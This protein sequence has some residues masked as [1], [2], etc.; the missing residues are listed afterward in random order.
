MGVALKNTDLRQE[1]AEYRQR[2][3][4][5]RELRYRAKPIKAHGIEDQLS[6][7]MSWSCPNEKVAAL[8]HLCRSL[9]GEKIEHA[10]EWQ[11]LGLTVSER[12]IVAALLKREGGAVPYERL[13]EVTSP[14]GINLNTLRVFIRYV[15]AKLQGVLTIEVD[16]GFGYRAKRLP[17]VVF[18]WEKLP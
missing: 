1:I 2:E 7:I 18:S 11:G 14:E 15:R 12:R 13:C 5:A 17:G 9:M 16:W 8:A 10:P 6:E 3:R 4:E